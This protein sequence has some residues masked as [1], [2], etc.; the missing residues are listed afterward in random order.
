MLLSF[1]CLLVTLQVFYWLVFVVVLCLASL[2]L[3][4]ERYP[5][6]IKRM[7]SMGAS[8]AT[9]SLFRFFLRVGFV[10]AAPAIV[11]CYLIL[12]I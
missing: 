7:M 11:S 4:R 9:V 3:F 1:G 2:A 12:N 5:P 8:M 6:M 10:M